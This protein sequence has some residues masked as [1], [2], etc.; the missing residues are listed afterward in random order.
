M[1]GG[2]HIDSERE[3]RMRRLFT[4]LV[5]LTLGCIHGPKIEPPST[6]MV[7]VAASYDQTWETAIAVFAERTYIINNLEKESGLSHRPR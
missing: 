4:G 6:A 7:P 5:L 1:M 2:S 3:D